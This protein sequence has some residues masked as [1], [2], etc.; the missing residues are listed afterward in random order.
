M[1]KYLSI[2]IPTNGMTEWVKIVLD[3][4]YSQKIDNSLYEVV[5][6]DNGSEDTLMQFIN[7][8][9][10]EKENLFYKKSTANGFLNQIECFKLANG[11]FIKFLNHR[12]KLKDGAIERLIDFARTHD[13][14]TVVFFSNGALADIGDTKEFNDFDSFVKELSIYSSWSGGLGIWKSQLEKILEKDTFNSLFPHTDILFFNKSANRYVIDNNLFFSEIDT[15][16]SKKGNY[17]VFY[18]FGV[19]YPNILLQLMTEKYISVETLHYLLLQN[20]KF[21]TNLYRDFIILKKPCSYN[22]ENY[23]NYLNIFYNEK[24]IRRHAFFPPV[25]R[26]I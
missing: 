8:Y 2:C 16:H 12:A 11:K 19:E 9:Y 20:C 22:L 18:A 17:N 7:Q 3:S 24:Q 13:D 4:I 5:I 26:R 15:Q 6:C 23:K 10:K 21:V 14:S 25:F 1:E